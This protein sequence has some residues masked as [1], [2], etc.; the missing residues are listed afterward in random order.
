MILLKDFSSFTTSLFRMLCLKKTYFIWSEVVVDVRMLLQLWRRQ[1]SLLTDWTLE[2]TVERVRVD[3]LVNLKTSLG[4][5]ELQ[6]EIALKVAW[7]AVEVLVA[8]EMGLFEEAFITLRAVVVAVLDVVGLFMVEEV[9]LLKE[10]FGADLEE[11]RIIKNNNKIYES[12]GKLTSQRNFGFS[13]CIFRCVKSPPVVWRILP[14]SG[15]DLSVL[16]ACFTFD[17][18]DLTW[19]LLC[20]SNDSVVSNS[21]LHLRQTFT[22]WT[23]VLW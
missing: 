18:A 21:R 10:F 1:K 22:P 7:F 4:F 3:L 11:I 19:L 23:V 5:V 8:E 15:H 12:S 13:K 17:T 16:F 2:R 14:Q 20:S 6:T 9:D